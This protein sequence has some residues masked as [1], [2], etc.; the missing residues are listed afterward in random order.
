MSRY[1]YLEEQ[2][3]IAQHKQFGKSTEGHPGQGELFNEAEGL[4]VEAEIAEETI[5]YTPVKSRHVNHCHKTCPAKLL[6]TILAT[7]KKSVA[8]VRANYIAL[9]KISRRSFSLS[10]LK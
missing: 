1:Q 5:S 6:F 2:F 9:V 8:V 4:V 3:R 10:L 7:K